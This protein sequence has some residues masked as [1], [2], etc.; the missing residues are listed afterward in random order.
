MNPLKSHLDFCFYSPN[1]QSSSFKKEL[2]WQIIGQMLLAKHSK[3][4][5]SIK[6]MESIL[7]KSGLSIVPTFKKMSELKLQELSTLVNEQILDKLKKKQEIKETLEE[8]QKKQPLFEK[9]GKR[10]Y[11]EL[12]TNEVIEEIKKSSEESRKRLKTYEDEIKKIS[13]TIKS[14][15]TSDN[16]VK[17]C[18][19]YNE[20]RRN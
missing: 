8:E 3:D 16:F 5:N 10:N 19:E 12:D 9:L 1:Y 13:E 15:L 20:K 6:A 2:A 11:R 14:G 7:K 18:Q 4:G 17:Y